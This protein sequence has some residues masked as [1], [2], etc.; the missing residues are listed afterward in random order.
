MP[1]TK[2]DVES[3]CRLSVDRSDGFRIA[4]RISRSR[5]YG[6]VGQAE[7]TICSFDFFIIDTVDRN[8]CSGLHF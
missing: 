8:G 4:S 7:E 2:D 6:V 5:C 3:R 1:H